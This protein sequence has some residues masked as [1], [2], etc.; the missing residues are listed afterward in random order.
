MTTE[1]CHSLGA[2]ALSEPL[3]VYLGQSLYC[4]FD[5]ATMVSTHT[6]KVS[7]IMERAI[8]EGGRRGRA[9]CFPRAV[10]QVSTTL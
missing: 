6:K 1:S 3:K 9:L 8:R 7:V 2:F 5:A 10:E 4:I